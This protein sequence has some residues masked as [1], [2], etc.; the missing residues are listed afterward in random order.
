METFIH[1][2]QSVCL[3]HS[4]RK[5]CFFLSKT[6]S[7]WWVKLLFFLMEVVNLFRSFFFHFFFLYNFEE[8]QIY[9]NIFAL[10]NAWS[11]Q[12]L[13]SV[14]LGAVSWKKSFSV[15]AV[16]CSSSLKSWT[17]C[18]ILDQQLTESLATGEFYRIFDWPCIWL[19]ID[20]YD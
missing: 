3:N 1:H 2:Q 4:W 10:H 9:P 16:F 5:H 15:H 7:K 19:W 12:C 13:Q 11:C 20:K 6:A 17:Q 14:I 8:S 18:D